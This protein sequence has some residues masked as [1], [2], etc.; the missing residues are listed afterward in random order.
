MGGFCKHSAALVL[1]LIRTT[2]AALG[3]A[4]EIANIADEDQ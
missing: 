4:H 3:L 1:H 2:N